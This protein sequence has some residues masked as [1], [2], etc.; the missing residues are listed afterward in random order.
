MQVWG[1]EVLCTGSGCHTLCHPV[2]LPASCL[3]WS[4]TPK[5][6]PLAP[7][8]LKAA[9]ASAASLA[10]AEE[11]LTQAVDIAQQLS[12]EEGGL[13]VESNKGCAAEL[14]AADAAR[15]ALAMLLCQSRRAPDAAVHLKALGFKFRLSQEVRTGTCLVWGGC[16]GTKK[17]SVAAVGVCS[18]SCK[19]GE[20]AGELQQSIACTWFSWK[21]P[22]PNA[23]ANWVVRPVTCLCLFEPQVLCYVVPKQQQQQRSTAAP[24]SRPCQEDPEQDNPG[25]SSSS[26]RC[27]F[28][29]VVDA[30]LPAP[31][32]QHLQHVFR[33]GADF[34]R[35]HSYGRV[36]YFSYFFPLVSDGPSWQLEGGLLLPRE[37]IQYQR[38]QSSSPIRLLHSFE[39]RRMT[40]VWASRCCAGA[41]A[42]RNLVPM[43]A[44]VGGPRRH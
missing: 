38:G 36:G 4:Q 20:T 35:E 23:D 43:R 1:R 39:K 29:Q 41:A 10:E 14:E 19:N 24:G 34:W 22:E 2:E 18:A 40:A 30:A 21:P 25:A 44:V 27:S 8:V 5:P 31:L 9:A 37:S 16:R 15:A 42:C 3:A 33:P 7:Q 26:S 28:M 11:V 12:E 17:P 13:L 6:R 32:L